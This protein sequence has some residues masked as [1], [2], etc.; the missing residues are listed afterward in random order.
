MGARPASRDRYDS[1]MAGTAG[2]FEIGRFTGQC[3]STGEPIA[4]GSP[5]VASLA[6]AVEEGRPVLRRIDWSAA[7][8]DSGARPEGLVC[9]W[10]GTAPNPGEKRRILLDDH[11][12]LEMVERLEGEADP[13]RVAYRWILALVLLRRKV[14]KLDRVERS[15]DEPPVERWLLR[16]KG[17]AEDAPPLALVNPQIRDEELRELADQLGELV[18]GEG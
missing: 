15:S 9:F 2:T 8:W 6:E 3:A 16:A 18:H 17:A 11:T 13:R 5:F 14:L 12:L 4:G 7:A 1:A 10:R